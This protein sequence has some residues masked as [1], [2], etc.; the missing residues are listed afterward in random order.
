[1]II[2]FFFFYLHPYVHHR[3]DH[4]DTKIETPKVTD[5]EEYKWRWKEE[6]KLKWWEKSWFGKATWRIFGDDELII[7]MEKMKINHILR[8]LRDN[9]VNSLIGENE[10]IK[11][12]EKTIDIMTIEILIYTWGEMIFQWPVIMLTKKKRKTVKEKRTFFFV[13]ILFSFLFFSKW[14]C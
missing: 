14:N 6:M 4:G 10:T 8:Q 13:L 2:L 12:K 9:L 5:R 11:S 1:M 3:H 7:L